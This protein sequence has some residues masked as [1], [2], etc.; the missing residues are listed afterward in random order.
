MTL[1]NANRVLSS[2][3]RGVSKAVPLDIQKMD[4]K[5]RQA[6]VLMRVGGALAKDEDSLDK[7]IA[8]A[9]EGKIR[10]M[11][12]SAH[13]PVDDASLVLA[14]V[15]LNS[16]TRAFDESGVKGLTA[17]TA[18]VF[19]DEG[20][21]IWR[22]HGD[23]ETAVLVKD[24]AD[25]IEAILSQRQSVSIATASTK[26]D[27]HEHASIG[28][29]IGWFDASLERMRYGVKCGPDMA[30]DLSSQSVHAIDE[31]SVF[32]V[33]NHNCQREV[34]ARYEE[35]FGKGNA[36]LSRDNGPGRYLKYMGLLFNQRETYF[37]RLEG[38]MQMTFGA[39]ALRR[40]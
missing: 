21:N 10:L 35:M 23:G 6:T 8:S 14:C 2:A 11:H 17:V 24:T 40:S 20:D 33:F 39:A 13:R 3:A 22:K 34:A 12:G 9:F 32:A 19:R 4:I 16:E 30:F 7:A 27:L 18:N 29:G 38:L 25:E 37:K 31:R 1:T 36:P 26:V 28:Q 15:E 5:D